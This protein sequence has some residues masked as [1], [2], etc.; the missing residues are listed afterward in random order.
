MRFKEG[1]WVII[2]EIDGYDEED[3]RIIRSENPH[4]ISD[5]EHFD[6]YENDLFRFDCIITE[7]DHTPYFTVD[8]LNDGTSI[9]LPA[10]N[11]HRILYLGASERH[12]GG[13]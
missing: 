4:K 6:L 9:V 7:G 1:D 11:L 12:L 10:T 3:V 13:Q 5:V 2:R 8:E